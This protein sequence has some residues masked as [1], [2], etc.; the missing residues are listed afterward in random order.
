MYGLAGGETATCAS[1]IF[2]SPRL[3][4]SKSRT[5][6][7][8]QS[9]DLQADDGTVVSVDYVPADL[10]GKV[11]ATRVWVS[12]RNPAF[13]GGEAV[14][15]RLVNY[16]EATTYS[17]EAPKQEAELNLPYKDRKSVV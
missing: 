2:L 16:Y 12:V 13:T 5:M 11:L 9:L 14:S 8:W 4:A 15:A 10:G 6:E 7:D 17:A 1:H 3:D